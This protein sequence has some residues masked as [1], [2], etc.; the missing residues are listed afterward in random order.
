M[1]INQSIHDINIINS[2]VD[3]K[4]NLKNCKKSISNIKNKL[5]IES[6]KTNKKIQFEKGD[7]TAKFKNNY[8]SFTEFLLRQ[9]EKSKNTIKLKI[10]NFSNENNNINNIKSTK[11]ISDRSNYNKTII[12]TISDNNIFNN[13]NEEN[14]SFRQQINFPTFDENSNES[15][16]FILIK[17]RNKN[18]EDFNLINDCLQKHFFMKT[19]NNQARTAII[20]EMSLIEIKKN[21]YIFMQ[22]KIGNYFY[23]M[24]SGK[25]ELVIN[26]KII[27]FF[28]IGDSFGE[29]A[30]LHDAPRSGSIITVSDCLLYILERKNFRKIV[31]HITKINYEENL[32]FIENVNILNHIESYQKSIL[33]SSLVR[34]EFEK[35]MFIVKKGEISNCLYI[36]KE[37]IVH[38]KDENGKIIRILKE[39]D[40]FGE[41]SVLCNIPRTMDVVAFSKKVICFS[42]SIKS[43]KSML[44]E[45]YRSYLFYNFLKYSL[46]I[47]KFFSKL[48]SLL[49]S[50]VFKYFEGINLNNDYCAFSKGYKKSS[51]FVIMID[52][53]LCKKNTNEIVFSRGEILFEKNLLLKDEEK[54]NFPLIPS[55]DALF[56]EA[57]TDLILNDLN[58]KNFNEIITKSEIIEILS[59][60]NLFKSL[61]K[62]KIIEISSKIEIE[63]FNKDEIIIKEGEIGDKFYI[64]KK[65]KIKIE[66]NKKYLRTLNEKDFFGERSLIT[67]KEKRSATAIA[68]EDSTELYSLNKENFLNSINNNIKN[69]LMNRYFLQDNSITLNDLYFVKELGSGNYGSVSLIFCEKNNFNYAIKAISKKHIDYECLH[70]NLNL[71][72]D[73][74]LKIDHPFIVKLVKCLKDKSNIYFLMEYLKGK[75]LFDVIRDIG[76]L[77]KAQSMFYTASMMEAINYLHERKFIYRDLKP[78]NIIVIE[79]GYIKLIDFGTCK[80]IEDRTNTIIGTPHYMA[81]EVILGEGYSF[82]V[83]F[84]SIGICLF[85]FIC[86]GVPFGETAEDPMEI[87][88]SIINNKIVFPL[89]VKDK[90]F[91]NLIKNML[92]KNPMLRLTTF[93]GIKRHIWFNGFNWEEL[94]MLN[95][96]A[97][98]LPKIK[99]LPNVAINKH[100]DDDCDISNFITSVSQNDNLSVATIKYTDYINNHMKE[101]MPEK[102]VKISRSDQ[103]KFNKWFE[104]F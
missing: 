59:K 21:K 90:E 86:G 98:Y 69:F 30:L 20:E 5:G 70:S 17:K 1:G 47:S 72:K 64:V 96:K 14:Y 6:K 3:E 28:H 31:E 100:Q 75:E 7:L 29:L 73:I 54:L 37:G 85:E 66:Q 81:P 49:I 52:G 41:L 39:G 68:I 62:N 97:P 24:K 84:W 51:N 34:E 25:S 82:E 80:E 93:D 103:E 77:N 61:S 91:K 35:N 23:I 11:N 63:K 19:L 42:I 18:R 8:K 44:S 60:I 57:K 10:N 40:N 58:C 9:K 43:L 27:K 36:I 48:N 76:L 2:N 83:D 32:K 94:N 38:C 101:W 45:K 50:Q 89:F 87:Y 67:K 46:K 65:G 56:I 4:I 15:D 74:L 22:N 33:S 104:N 79:N 99:S 26:N 16:N 71:E 92:E 53:N 102:E 78:E 55:P 12:N 88:I 95:L 13:L